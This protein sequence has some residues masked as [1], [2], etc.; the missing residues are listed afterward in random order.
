MPT[1]LDAAQTR[2][3]R[4]SVRIL[5]WAQPVLPPVE[6]LLV[7]GGDG[8]IALDADGVAGLTH[9]VCDGPMVLKAVS[10]RAQ[11]EIFLSRLVPRQQDFSLRSK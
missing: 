5:R 10:F 6:Q 8:R 9:T 4:T 3:V 1:A 7:E 11:R 2:H